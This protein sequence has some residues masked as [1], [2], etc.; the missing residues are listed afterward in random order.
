MQKCYRTSI[1]I[2][3]AIASL[4][5]GTIVGSTSF[6]EDA[7]GWKRS[8]RPIPTAPR[9]LDSRSFDKM[10]AR[11][12]Q[13]ESKTSI[14]VD[15]NVQSVSGS[16][17]PKT[18]AANVNSEGKTAAPQ[19]AGQVWRS[20]DI[21][22]YVRRMSDNTDVELSKQPPEQTIVDWIVRETGTETWFSNPA[23]MLS[24]N[25]N[26][27]RV[28]HTPEVQRTVAR[29]VERF[30]DTRNDDQFVVARIMSVVNVNWRIAAQEML[31]PVEVDAAG[32]EAWLLSREHAARLLADLNRRQDFA[33]HDS[34][35]KVFSGEVKS[36]DRMRS[37]TYP[38]SI[39]RTGEAWPGYRLQNGKVDVGFRLTV[40]PLYETNG[41]STEATLRFRVE[42]VER[43]DSMWVDVPIPGDPRQRVQIQVPQT[44]SWQLHERF[45]WPTDHVLLI[46]CGK[47]AKSPRRKNLAGLPNLAPSRKSDVLLMLSNRRDDRGLR[48]DRAEKVGSRAAGEGSLGRA[49]S[50][51]SERN[52]TSRRTRID[53]RGRY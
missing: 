41:E 53:T 38:Q 32:V 35:L 44:N 27:L 31:Q 40:S 46:S 36:I 8:T 1:A 9:K 34:P 4:L 12:V 29:I 13:S 22:R 18:S 20:Y 6:A 7:D 30:N 37:S 14:L 17:E 25:E 5:A 47:I 45:R 10:A 19:N 3:C 49:G 33:V 11:S 15:R 16:A 43:F 2:L 26:A 23:G 48:G 39:Q 50:D 51:L 24:A 21:R 52:Q 42:Q 28:Y